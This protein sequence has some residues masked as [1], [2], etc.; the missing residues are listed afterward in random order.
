LL[1]CHH[2]RHRVEETRLWRA[3]DGSAQFLFALLLHLERGQPKGPKQCGVGVGTAFTQANR[4]APFS[5]LLRELGDHIR[6]HLAGKHLLDVLGR[7]TQH[8]VVTRQ[9]RR[10]L[11]ASLFRL[12]LVHRPRQPV[13]RTQVSD[14]SPDG[15]ACGI[16]RGRDNR[17]G[18]ISGLAAARTPRRGAA[19]KGKSEVCH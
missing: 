16:D 6:R 12:K 8:I 10:D 9:V 4:R 14:V 18:A 13:K 11:T 5:G 15:L 19:V 1:G 3:L 2:H 7:F 17:L